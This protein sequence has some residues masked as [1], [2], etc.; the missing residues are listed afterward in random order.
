MVVTE[1]T[2]LVVY[3]HTSSKQNTLNTPHMMT[4]EVS[5]QLIGR[6]LFTRSITAAAAAYFVPHKRC[7]YLK[8]ANRQKFVPSFFRCTVLLLLLPRLRLTTAAAK[9]RPMSPM[10]AQSDACA[11]FIAHPGKLKAKIHRQQRRI[12]Y[13]NL[14]SVLVEIAHPAG[15]ACVLSLMSEK[16]RSQHNFES[17]CIL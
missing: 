1:Y 11:G 3:K 7:V 12:I 14:T 13:I 8:H 10:C 2:I 17:P 9:P 4:S 15:D 5:V 6:M 16:T